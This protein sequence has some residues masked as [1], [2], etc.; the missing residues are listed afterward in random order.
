MSFTRVVEYEIDI[1]YTEVNF[2]GNPV[3]AM[4]LNGGIPG[5]ILEFTEGDTLRVTF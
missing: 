1:A 4:T 3:M 5:P 2:T